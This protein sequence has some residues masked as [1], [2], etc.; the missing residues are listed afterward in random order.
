MT[1]GKGDGFKPDGEFPQHDEMQRPEYGA[2]YFQRVAF[3]YL[4]LPP[5]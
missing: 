5:R 1:R 2:D 3:L 4:E